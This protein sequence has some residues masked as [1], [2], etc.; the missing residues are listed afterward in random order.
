MKHGKQKKQTDDFNN[1]VKVLKQSNHTLNVQPV[2]GICYGKIKTSYL[3]GYMKA[4]GQN[5]WYL[6]SGEESLYI[7]IIEPIGYEAK[8][9]NDNFIRKKNEIINSFTKDFLNEFCNNGVIDWNKL[10]EYNSGNLDL[11]N[12]L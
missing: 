5:F 10:V 3:H 9:H 6:I 7:D 12:K 4:V 1:A 2:L 8:K 11:V